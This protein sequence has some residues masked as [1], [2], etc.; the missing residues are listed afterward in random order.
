MPLYIVGAGLSADYL[1]RRAIEILALAEKVYIDTYTSIAPGVT[2]DLV[3]RV[4]PWAE[5]VEAS[6]RILEDES[7]RIVEEAS[8]KHVVILVPG[9]PFTATTH[10]AIA[11]EAR[12][13]GVR[14]EVVPGIPG[15]YTAALIVGLQS[16]RIGKMVTLT[17]PE[18]GY[19]PYSTIETIWS[20]YERNLHTIVLL[21]LRL[22]E[23]KAMKVDEAVRILVN[24]ENEVSRVEGRRPIIA[25]A[26]MVGIARAGLPDQKCIAGKPQHLIEEDWPPPPHTV[27]VLA[28]NPHPIEIEALKYLCSCRVCPKR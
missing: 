18:P 3:A 24:L 7:W 5:V 12:R 23:D 17:Y 20:N 2:R 22:D 14:V 21:D 11:V 1:T 26:Y 19:K 25:E 16:Y 9:D 13:R 8:R 28:P 15:P 10:V 6:R 4:N 27:I